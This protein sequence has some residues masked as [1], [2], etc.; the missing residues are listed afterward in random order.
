MGYEK[1]PDAKSNLIGRCD[2][3]VGKR[4]TVTKVIEGIDD[5]T[6]STQQEVK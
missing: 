4:V 2:V 6:D 3:L 5:E 1:Q